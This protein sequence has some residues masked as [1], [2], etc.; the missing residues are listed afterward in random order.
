M[1]KAIANLDEG[2]YSSQIYKEFQKLIIRGGSSFLEYLDTCTFQTIQMKNMKK[3]SLSSPNKEKIFAAHSSCLLDH[4][5]LSQE[6]IS[7][8]VISETEN[9]EL[10]KD[11]KNK[12]WWV[13]PKIRRKEEYI[14]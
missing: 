4:H 9:D 12:Y 8:N 6:H 11:K 13:S 10:I 5:F 2:S 14:R 7:T 1:L 3:L